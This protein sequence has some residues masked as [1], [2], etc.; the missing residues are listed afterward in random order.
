MTPAGIPVYMQIVEVMLERIEHAA[1]APGDRLAAERTLATEFGVNR[2]TI[3]QALEVLE[4]RGLV[5]RRQGAGTFVS[6]PRIER[7]AAEF[8]H[9]TEDIRQRGLAAGSRELNLERAV[10]SPFVATELELS[11]GAEIYRCHRL[12]TINSQPILIETFALPAD[13]VPGF[14]LWDMSERSVYEVM[15]TE[16]DIDVLYARQS[17]EAVA[18]SEIEAQWLGATPGAPAML[19]RRL[20]FDDRGRPVDYGTDLYRGDRVRFVTD[21]ATVA[22]PIT[23][24]T[25]SGA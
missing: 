6:E 21:A 13:L 15:R 18:L 25:T 8:F 19:E 11:P 16:Y 24:K 14:E 2:R 17:L 10:P 7:G 20:A 1:L 22:V 12:R 23:D 3:R 5:Q 4:R 9:F